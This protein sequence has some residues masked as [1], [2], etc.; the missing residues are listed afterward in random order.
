MH[1]SYVCEPTLHSK[2]QKRWAY[3]GQRYIAGWPLV[4]FGLRAPFLWMVRRSGAGPMLTWRGFAG[5][6]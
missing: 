6:R 2:W 1:N 4:Q 5:T 3:I